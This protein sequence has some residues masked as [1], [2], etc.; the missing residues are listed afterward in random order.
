MLG[1][2]IKEAEETAYASITGNPP[3]Q[4]R[5]G[6][7]VLPLDIEDAVDFLDGDGP[8]ISGSAA[9]SSLSG[10]FSSAGY[11][12]RECYRR[13]SPSIHRRRGGFL[14]MELKFEGEIEL[15]ER[16]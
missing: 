12:A 8:G 7:P 3:P 6:T 11:A 2:L 13:G 1:L 16:F 15:G 9:T 10:S 4:Q 5:C 14:Q